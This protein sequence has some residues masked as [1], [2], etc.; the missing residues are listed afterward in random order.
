MTDSGAEDGPGCRHCGDPVE[1]S[2]D[3]RVVSTVDDGAANHVHFCS[4]D[5]LTAW[6][7]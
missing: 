6:E 2:D 1:S 3:R 7:S 5:C 4:T